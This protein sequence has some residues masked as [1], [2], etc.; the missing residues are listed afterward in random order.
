[1]IDYLALKMTP[2]GSCQARLLR[3]AVGDYPYAVVQGC[4][5]PFGSPLSRI[6]HHCLALENRANK[7]A[8]EFAKNL[9]L[10]DDIAAAFAACAHPYVDKASGEDPG[11]CN[12]CGSIRVSGQ[13]L[14]PHWRDV[15]HD[16]LF[17]KG[18]SG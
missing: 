6:C 4:P 16:F 13:W 3:S 11:W 14:Q 7:A 1:M 18:G 9:K 17:K 2:P 5:G 10:T 8:E 15:V 12:V